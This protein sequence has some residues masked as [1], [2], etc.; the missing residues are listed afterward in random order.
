MEKTKDVIA[1]KP[2]EGFFFLIILAISL[3]LLATPYY[4][5]SIIPILV[6]V[7]FFLL[8]RKPQLGYYLIV[9]LIPFDAFRGLT[10]S[11]GFLTISKLVG[12][13]IFVL[14]LF[15]I[16][17]KKR[18]PLSLK[19]NLW[20][21]FAIFLVIGLISALLSDYRLLAF[22]TLRQLII[23]YTFFALTLFFLS[24][25][26]FQKI[27]PAVLVVSITISSL[28]SIIGYIFKIKLFIFSVE[29]L[30]R[31]IGPSNDPNFFACMI[32]FSIPFILHWF[33]S[34]HRFIVKCIAGVA[35]IINL[36]AVILTYSRGGAMV[37]AVVIIF[38]F[39]EHMRR[40]RPRYLGFFA[41]L[42]TIAVVAAVVLVPP[43]YWTRQKS[44]FRSDESIG[45]RMSYLYVGWHAFKEKPLLGAGPGTFKEIYSGT[46]YA[47]QF[48]ETTAGEEP[49]SSKSFR[50]YAHNTY[51]EVLVGTGLLGLAVFLA[52][53]I[54]TLKNFQTAKNNFKLSGKK[55]MASLVGAYRISFISILSYFFLIS[56]IQHKYFWI[57]LALSQLSVSLSKKSKEEGYSE[58]IPL[59]Q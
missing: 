5:Y 50:R 2:I 14:M 41:L 21:W 49:L 40:F 15:Y 26:G 44:V 52:I 8:A 55:D 3:G 43:T 4:M 29:T 59:S 35:L 34:S 10:D 45:A 39:I 17:F 37:L 46:P 18:I 53:L 13:W 7:F 9:F 33:F 27:L 54:L 1:F 48:H 23:A 38:L 30:Q 20:A 32:I 36:A 25:K 24:D 31:A 28:L 47:L 22:D 6:I 16:L 56:A 42:I 51:M 11:V 19:S 12:L 57:A 58:T